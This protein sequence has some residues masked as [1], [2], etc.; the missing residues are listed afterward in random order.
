MIKIKKST[1]ADTRS[2]DPSTVSKEQLLA[3]SQSHISDVRQALLDFA[4]QLQKTAEKHD[5]D[6]ISDIDWFYKDFQTG[7]KETGWWDNH[8][9]INRHHIN[10]E[11]GIPEDVDLID[12]LEFISD[13]IMAGMARTGHVYPVTLNPET[14][15]KAF[16]NTVSKLLSKVEVE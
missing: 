1:T 7:F 4:D 13:C 14:L 12:V 10:Y 11:D 5:H 16:E 3:S 2:C 15:N 8:R 6:K 9:K